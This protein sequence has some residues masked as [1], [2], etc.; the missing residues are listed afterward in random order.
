MTVKVL[1]TYGSKYGATKE[2]AEKIGQTITQEGLP[3]DVISAEKVKNIVDYQAVVIG[4]AA[5]IGGWR[6]EVINF[7]KKNEKALTERPVWIFSSGPVEK[8]DPVKLLKGWL[9][10][11]SL[12]PVIDRIKPRDITAFH[13]VISAGKINIIEK[14]MMKMVKAEPGDYRDWAMIEKWAKGIAATARR[15]KSAD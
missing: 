13:G 11:K 14:Q 10:P 5:Y 8:G 3:V 9:Y 1:V 2:I 12:K 4:S 6:K 15:G 7:V